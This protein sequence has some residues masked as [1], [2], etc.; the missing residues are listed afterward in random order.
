[1]YLIIILLKLEAFKSEIWYLKLGTKRLNG[2]WYK[3]YK[4]YNNK[5]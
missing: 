3:Y 2:C 1:M 4:Y 5:F